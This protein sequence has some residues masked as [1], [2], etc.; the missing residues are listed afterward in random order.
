MLLV[1]PDQNIQRMLQATLEELNPQELRA[2]SDHGEAL[3]VLRNET[4]THLIFSTT[5]T[6]ADAVEFLAA[7]I[8][9]CPDIVALPS[10][11]QQDVDLIFDL[12]MLGA[13]AY[14]LL[15]VNAES[16]NRI[17]AIATRTESIPDSLTTGHDKF[18]TISNMLVNCVDEIANTL[19]AA[20][21]SGNEPN[22]LQDLMAKFRDAAEMARVF[23][24]GTEHDL[25]LA[26][27]QEVCIN[28]AS[29]DTA[30]RLDVLRKRIDA[31]KKVRDETD[32]TAP[33]PSK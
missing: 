5:V 8:S 3:Q 1:E 25:L 23:T 4:Y 28:R 19:R 11:R 21:E 15:P 33:D 7:A 30:T 20:K 16:L 6:S 22:G 29:R 26:S 13:R 17:V 14:I 18:R 10:S 27:V 12:L 32:K 2:L 9:I 31:I 24:S